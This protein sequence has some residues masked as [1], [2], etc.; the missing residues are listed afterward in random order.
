MTPEQIAAGLPIRLRDAL[1]SATEVQYGAYPARYEV[2]TARV[3]KSLI[4]KKLAYASGP[5][6]SWRPRS[7]RAVL[8]EL[9]LAV[10]DIL[11]EAGN[12]E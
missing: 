9:G 1:L 11:K 12:G 5:V 2:R 10:R 4:D 6:T 3:W 7:D 8:N